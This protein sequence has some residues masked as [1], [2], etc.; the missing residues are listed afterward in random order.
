MRKA[1]PTYIALAVAI[2]LGLGLVLAEL[3]IRVYRYGPDSLLPSVM[4]SLHPIGTSGMIRRSI[5]ELGYEL[6]PDLDELYKKVPFQTNSVGL[7]DR[8]YATTKP[9]DT[10]RTAVIGDSFTMPTGVP[11]EEAYHSRLEDS[12]NAAA[13]GKGSTQRY[14]FLNFGV[15]GYQL[16]QYLAILRERALPYQP[17]LVLVALSTNDHIFFQSIAD[18]FKEPYRVKEETFP[19]FELELGPWL[20]RTFRTG[21]P[22][23]PRQTQLTPAFRAHV[24]EYFGRLKALAG[25]ADVPIAVVFL[26]PYRWQF[27]DLREG[28]ASVAEQ[29]GLPFID[30]SESLPEQEDFGLRIFRADGHPNGAANALFAETI[31]Q[32]LLAQG[33]VPAP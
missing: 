28:L 12:L 6:K 14:E 2:G 10:F 20:E 13:G 21:A 19:F 16:P 1:R 23:N 30:A 5:P 15:G 31:E 3:A 32:S 17:D 29:Y 11:I 9:K 26:A 18:K 24:E 25:S 33:L 22:Q 7:R 27:E 4:N 8:E